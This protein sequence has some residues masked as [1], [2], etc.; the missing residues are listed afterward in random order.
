MPMTVDEYCIGQLYS[1][2]KLSRENTKGNEGVKVLKNEP[3]EDGSGQYTQK[4]YEIGKT[5]MPRWVTVIIPRLKNLSLVEESWN[6][7][8]VCLTQYASEYFGS[9]FSLEVKTMHLNDTGTTENVHNLSKDELKQ[10]EIVYLDISNTEDLV[11]KKTY[12]EEKDPKHFKSEKTERGPL[13]EDWQKRSN[14]VMCCYKLV[15]VVTKAWWMPSKLARMVQDF[16]RGAMIESNRDLFLWIDEWIEMDME[17]IRK[18][19]DEVQ[20]ELKEAFEK[21]DG[22]GGAKNEKA[23]AA[24]G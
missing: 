8:P 4:I 23:A 5:L 21:G 6:R 10:R 18:L 13:T 11:S 12:S 9:D 19:E 2:A 3:I 7:Y 24:K 15:K 1:V 22:K 16:S 14:P 20:Q 17:D